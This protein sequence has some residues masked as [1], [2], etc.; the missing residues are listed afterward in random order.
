MA[1][2]PDKPRLGTVHRV[3]GH[4]SRLPGSLKKK[5]ESLRNCHRPVETRETCGTLEKKNSNRK[6]G[7]NPNSLEYRYSNVFVL[8]NIP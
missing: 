8:T 5:K 2:A 7:K 1:K 4:S 3:N 6:C